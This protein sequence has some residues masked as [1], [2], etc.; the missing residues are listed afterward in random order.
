MKRRI[1]V[2]FK[3]IALFIA[4][5]AVQTGF[6]FTDVTYFNSVIA[7]DNYFRVFTPLT[8]DSADAATRYPVIYFL[9]GCRGSHMYGDRAANGYNDFGLTTP[10]VDSAHGTSPDYSVPYNPD[11]E[12]YSDTAKVI[13]VAC[14]GNFAGGGCGAWENQSGGSIDLP[15]FFKVLMDTVDSRYNTIATPAGRAI[16]GI[17]MGG[18]AASFIAANL[19][20]QFLSASEFCRSPAPFAFDGVSA[21]S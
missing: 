15:A 18:F 7:Q 14:N 16:T 10:L 17:S 1:S 6:G 8:Y 3:I 19:P 9:H 5:I 2:S 13:I 20:D 21:F 11:F 4:G 12:N